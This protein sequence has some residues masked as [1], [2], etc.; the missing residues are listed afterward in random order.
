MDKNAGVAP[1]LP[2]VDA[3]TLGAEST[4]RIV[5]AQLFAE[6]LKGASRARESGTPLKVKSFLEE[7]SLGTTDI[8]AMGPSVTFSRNKASL[9]RE[10]RFVSDAALEGAESRVAW[11]PSQAQD[12]EDRVHQLVRSAIEVLSRQAAMAPEQR[13][14]APRRV[15]PLVN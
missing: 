12:S 2:D 1:A 15:E 14:P 7:F 5:Q 8:V 3:E 10:F 11:T 6:A 13:E 9:V 4:A